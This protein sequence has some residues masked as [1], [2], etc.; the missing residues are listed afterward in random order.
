[1]ALLLAAVTVTVPVPEW[2]LLTAA[3]LLLEAG[4]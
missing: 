2:A 3:A 1:M 4:S